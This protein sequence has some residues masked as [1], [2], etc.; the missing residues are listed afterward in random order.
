MSGH[1]PSFDHEINRKTLNTVESLMTQHRF[2]AIS[3]GQLETGLQAIW[4]CTAGIID[5]Q[6]LDIVTN[7]LND[8]EHTGC[9]DRR[10]FVKPDNTVVSVEHHMLRRQVK[11][12]SGPSFAKNGWEV[13]KIRTFETSI[14]QPKDAKTWFDALCNRLRDDYHEI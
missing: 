14:N 12:S 10:L 4:G 3:H 5:N 6:V 1:L 8:E 2:G 9:V 11:I 13:Q 7:L